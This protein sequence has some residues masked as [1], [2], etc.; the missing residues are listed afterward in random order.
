MDKLNEQFVNYQILTVNDLL[1][2]I[3]TACGIGIWEEDEK[4]CRMDELWGFLKGYRAPGTTELM[5]NQLFKVVEFVLINPH[6]NAGEER[7]FS[8]INKN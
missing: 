1:E 5:I 4:V 2:H 6:T 8:Y 7:L 3:K